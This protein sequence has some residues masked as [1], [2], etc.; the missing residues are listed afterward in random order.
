VF[1]VTMVLTI[2]MILYSRRAKVEAF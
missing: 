2:V 1:A